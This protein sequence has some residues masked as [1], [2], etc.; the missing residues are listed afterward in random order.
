MA[1]TVQLKGAPQ[2]LQSVL[3][4]PQNMTGAVF[5][6]CM[7]TS[8]ACTRLL[9]GNLCQELNTCQRQQC[10]EYADR[11][12]A[13]QFCMASSCSDTYTECLGTRCVPWNH[14]SLLARNITIDFSR[15]KLDHSYDEQ[16]AQ[17]R[18]GSTADSASSSATAGICLVVPPL[19]SHCDS[20]W[21]IPMVPNSQADFK[22]DIFAN[23]M[24][25]GECSRNVVMGHALPGQS[26]KDQKCMFGTCTMSDSVCSLLS[27]TSSGSPGSGT[28]SSSAPFGMIATLVFVGLVSCCIF[29]ICLRR[30]RSNN[31]IIVSAVGQSGS[32]PM[33][34][35]RVVSQSTSTIV[36]HPMTV[37]DQQRVVLA[38]HTQRVQLAQ[39][40]QQHLAAQQQLRARQEA[41][42]RAYA[43]LRSAHEQRLREQEE[44]QGEQELQEALQELF[45][46]MVEAA[47]QRAAAA[48][49]PPPPD[50][51]VDLTLP[52][53]SRDPAQD[54]VQI[55]S[56]ADNILNPSS[57]ASDVA[58][59]S[60]G[61]AAL[62]SRPPSAHPPIEPS[63]PALPRDTT[64]I[65]SAPSAYSSSLEI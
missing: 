23:M 52:V 26:C 39:Q 51:E 58:G 38:S 19:G 21:D 2:D 30:R 12:D 33:A 65:P 55:K 54:E 10:G 24:S 14:P 15:S 32:S 47:T 50:P 25:L 46:H 45:A 57:A 37:I 64:L 31:T 56:N 4:F 6:A 8:N 1:S 20:Q 36:S 22:D 63:A 44:E 35:A 16:V 9:E 48:V 29:V 18:S 7:T 53:Y 61:F 27:S 49:R 5:A 34:G 59:S 40:Q 42:A 28:T 11:Y 62:P 43:Q 17:Y 41:E 3:S 13:W 60:S